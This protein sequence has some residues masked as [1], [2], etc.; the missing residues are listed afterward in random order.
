MMK[1]NY[2]FSI[3]SDYE[4]YCYM[5]LSLP[6]SFTIV[7][8]P[9]RAYYSEWDFCYSI[10]KNN[11]LYKK[12]EGSFKKIKKGELIKLAKNILSKTGERK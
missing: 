9:Q 8:L 4:F 10:Y 12:I 2:S 11:K 3:E 7:S 6:E 5:K 1:K